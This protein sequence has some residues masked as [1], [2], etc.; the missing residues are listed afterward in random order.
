MATKKTKKNTQLDGIMSQDGQII[1][2]TG[3]NEADL[4]KRA[5]SSKKKYS[6]GK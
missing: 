3:S 2:L 5:A 1:R 4:K 6:K